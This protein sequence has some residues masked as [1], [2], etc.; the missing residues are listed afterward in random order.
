MKGLLTG[1]K[2]FI[3]CAENDIIGQHCAYSSNALRVIKNTQA[4]AELFALN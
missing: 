3:N 4:A 2:I 1:L